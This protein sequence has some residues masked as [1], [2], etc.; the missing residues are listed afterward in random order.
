[1]LYFAYGSNLD[2]KSVAA[3]AKHFGHKTP[4]LRGGK[5]AILDNYRLAFP[6]FSEYWGGGT[7][8]IVYDPGKSVSGAVFELS[9]K[10][11]ALL[12][13]KVRRRVEGGDDVGVYKRIEVEVRPMTRGPAVKA[14][15][16]QGVQQ[17]AFHIP[18]T[19][20]YVDALVNG[21]FEHGLS[22]MWVS[23]LQSF[24]TQAGKPPRPPRATR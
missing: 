1:M 14:W 5:P 10:D 4:S 24:S 21:A 15:T 12:D 3:W 16:Y 17:E 22:T 13:Q 2:Q 9:D 19:Q 23:Y 20:N 8:D 7:A 6:V 18:P 11:W